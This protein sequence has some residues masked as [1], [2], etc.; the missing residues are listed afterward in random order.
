MIK[1]K[2]QL[3]ELLEFERDSA[4]YNIFSQQC[5]QQYFKYY[6]DRNDT[7]FELPGVDLIDGSTLKLF[8]F[9][10][11]MDKIS[12]DQLVHV[13]R[14]ANAFITRNWLKEVFRT[15]QSY[16]ED[17]G[18]T[19]KLKTEGWYHFARLYVNAYSHD[20]KF[21]FSKTDKGFLPVSYKNKTITEE[22]EGNQAY[23]EMQT[24]YELVEDIISFAK[25]LLK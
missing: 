14:S 5:L 17:K 15:V 7:P 18:S 23:L 12:K 6:C 1:N 2:Q 25:S 3:I 20:S 10:S 22:M 8:D 11:E 4:C 21:S 16:A 9:C 24:A 19:D 13:K